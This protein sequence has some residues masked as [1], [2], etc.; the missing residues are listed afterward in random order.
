M[1][2]IPGENAEEFGTALELPAFTLKSAKETIDK[3]T[4]D[5]EHIRE[6]SF[7]FYVEEPVFIVATFPRKSAPTS[8]TFAWYLCVPKTHVVTTEKRGQE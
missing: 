7:P 2:L 8:A 1:E 4:A 6:H 5:Y 3:L